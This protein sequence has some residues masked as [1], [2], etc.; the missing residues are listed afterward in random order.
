[1]SAL[2]AIRPGDRV[3]YRISYGLPDR[4]GVYATK[5]KW[6]KAM[7][8]NRDGSVVLDGGGRYGIPVVLTKDEHVVKVTPA[9]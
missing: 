4:D 6:G 5:E 1:V 7:L 9:R 3:K 8:R 2:S